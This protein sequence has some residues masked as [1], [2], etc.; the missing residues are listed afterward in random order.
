MADGPRL[1]QELVFT[2]PS[3]GQ[4]IQHMAKEGDDHPESE[5]HVVICAAC[6]RLHFINRKTK[7]LF[8][9]D[10]DSGVSPS[11][12]VHTSHVV[13]DSTSIKDERRRRLK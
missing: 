6:T 3:S 8:I 4:T 10:E 1:T 12:R 9:P 11:P 2:C 5:H 13:F 7:K